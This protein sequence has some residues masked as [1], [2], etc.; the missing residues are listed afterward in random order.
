MED[1][2]AMTRKELAA[3]AKELGQPAFRGNQLFDLMLKGAE[4]FEQLTNLPVDF[5]R[6]LSNRAYISFA[7]I[8]RKF[9]SQIDWTVK[10]LFRLRDGKYVESVVMEYKHGRSICI[11]T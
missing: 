8:E 1:L 9:I 3:L 7:R 6:A 11:S 2:K 10:Y 4:D 5:R